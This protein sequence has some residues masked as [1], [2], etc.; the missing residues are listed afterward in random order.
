MNLLHREIL[1]VHMLLRSHFESKF[2]PRQFSRKFINIG[3]WIY[4]I[5]HG[6]MEYSRRAGADDGLDQG[7]CCFRRPW[8]GLWLW[9]CLG[10]CYGC[11]DLGWGNWDT[12]GF[13]VEG[14]SQL[15]WFLLGKL[16]S[17]M[18]SKFGGCVILVRHYARV[19]FLI[20][21]QIWIS[22]FF[23]D[24]EQTTQPQSS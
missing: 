23:M 2:Y 24:P 11:C 21:G 3:T 18:R 16:E 19:I 20:L 7:S 6:S 13:Q 15:S 9:D 1:V 17:K 12:E 22:Q 5:L 8:E 4:S 10:G 14:T